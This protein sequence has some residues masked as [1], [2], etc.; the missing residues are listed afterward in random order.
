M[1]F[2]TDFPPTNGYINFLVIKNKLNKLVIFEL[3]PSIE[4]E[5]YVEAFL[6]YFIKYYSWPNSIINN[7]GTNWTSRF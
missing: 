5:V 3:I 6:R 1:D 7:K 4:V 2:I